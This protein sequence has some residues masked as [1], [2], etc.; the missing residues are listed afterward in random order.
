[1]RRKG[2]WS[3]EHLERFLSEARIPLR[4]ACNGASGAP[5][6]ASL[7]FVPIEGRLWCATQR[8]AHV[9]SHLSR[10]PRCAFEV[11]VDTPPYR[12]VRGQ[13]LARLH[14]ARGEPILRTLVQRYLE[15]SSSEFARWLLSRADRETA[16][17][18][19]PR[20]LVTWDYGRRM[21]PAD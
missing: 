6:L 2:P 16:I 14:D 11:A 20:A 5:V 7:W 13:G 17:E 19:E 18:I 4:L 3:Q 21:S 10:D 15:D 9:V 1:M 8:S 12:G